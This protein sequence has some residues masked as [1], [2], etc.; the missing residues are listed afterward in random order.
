ML[1]GLLVE[2][3]RG[4]K[5]RLVPVGSIVARSARFSHRLALAPGCASACTL[6]I[7]GPRIR[8]WGFW[9][10]KGWR[11]WKEFTAPADSGNIGRGC[12]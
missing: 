1:G 7:T 6:F 2:H 10:P 9:C 3:M 5:R 4:G 11:H 8:E 12:D